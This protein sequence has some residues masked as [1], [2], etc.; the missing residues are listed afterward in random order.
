MLLADVVSMVGL[1][2]HRFT[3]TYEHVVIHR[4]SWTDFESQT[5][6]ADFKSIRRRVDYMQANDEHRDDHR[7][8]SI[9]TL[10]SSDFSDEDG[11]EVITLSMDLFTILGIE[12]VP[13]RDGM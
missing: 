6:I 9:D 4:I 5:M 13:V 2:R 1:T 3:S 7:D 10:S 12:V 11:I 8:T